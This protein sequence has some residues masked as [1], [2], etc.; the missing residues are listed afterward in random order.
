MAINDKHYHP[1][2]AARL[3]SLVAT[4]DWQAITSYLSGLSNAQFRT[5]GYL[6]AEEHASKLPEEDLWDMTAVMVTYNS[7]AMLVTLLH[8]IADRLKQKEI[9]LESS[10]FENFAN[11]IKDKEIDT[12]KVLLQLL[13]SL[14][15]P[16][17][18]NL[19]FDKLNVAQGEAR[20]PF[21]LRTTTMPA[22]YVLLRNL[23]HVE[24]DRSFLIRTVYF[25]IK[26]GDAL[27]YNLASMLRSAFGLEEIRGTFSL[28]VEPYQLARLE[29]S[30]TAFC[31][32]L[33]F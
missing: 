19:L 3:R 21:L 4:K 17:D 33:K 14:E 31:Q 1:I 32:A 22:S 7:K 9:S 11:L 28:K 12:Q 15:K 23:R 16:E 30:Y 6:L 13:P 10:G 25:L 29:Q 27:S 5:A 26:R 2:V 18:I 20:I 24:H 8:P